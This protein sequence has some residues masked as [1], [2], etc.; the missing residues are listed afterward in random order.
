MPLCILALQNSVFQTD[1]AVKTYIS[2]RHNSGNTCL[3]S[4]AQN[5]ITSTTFASLKA[6][7][8]KKLTM[9]VHSHWAS[10]K[11]YYGDKQ[12][13]ADTAQSQQT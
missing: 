10:M 7:L 8:L 12:K 4:Q 13:R 6:S 9:Q 1:K 3:F 5:Q 11:E 2:H